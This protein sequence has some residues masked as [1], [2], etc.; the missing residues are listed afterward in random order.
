MWKLYVYVGKKYREKSDD[1]QKKVYTIGQKSQWTAITHIRT[2]MVNVK[3]T[4]IV[5]SNQSEKQ[6][7][8]KKN[9]ADSN[10]Y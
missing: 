7:E 9:L 3:I 2:C 6:N 10:I 1:I 8:E 4:C 5:E